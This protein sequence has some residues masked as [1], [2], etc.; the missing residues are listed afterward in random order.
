MPFLSSKPTINKDSGA[1]K[2]LL[3]ARVPAYRK[4]FNSICSIV[5]GL[6]LAGTIHLCEE[7]N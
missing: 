3:T 6:C 5:T 7:S 4:P 1:L 2:F